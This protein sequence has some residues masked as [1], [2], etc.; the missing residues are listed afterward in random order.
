MAPPTQLSAS[1]STP[2]AASLILLYNPIS[3]HGHLDSWNALFIGFLLEAGWRVASLSPGAE[4]LRARLGLRQLAQHPNLKILAWRTPARSFYQRVRSRVTRL[5]KQL[6]P[7]A[8]LDPAQVAQL[9]Q[10]EAAYLQPQEFAE[11]V[12][13]ATQQLGTRPAFVFNMYMDLYRND[14]LGWRPFRDLHAI[15]WGGIRFVPSSV[16]P[17]EAYYALSSLAGMCFLDEQVQQAYSAA[18]PHKRFEYL[19]DV[20][21]ASLP[22]TASEFVLDLK[23]RAA[24]RKIVFLGGTIGSNKN[25]SQ[26]FALIAQANPAQWFFVQLGEVHE[27]NLTT[28]DLSAYR[29]A[30]A[31]TPEN[32]FIYPQY[33]PDER[34][35]N[36]VIALSDIIFAVYRKFGI[37]SNM[38][39]KAAAFEKPIL[40]AEGY[41]MGARVSA[42]QI[43]LAVP[44]DDSAKMLQALTTLA[45]PLASREVA[46]PKHFAAYRQ[47]FSHDALK[48]KFFH[49]LEQAGARSLGLT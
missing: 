22:A 3:G 8:N 12:A 1:R 44:E 39:G 48:A 49:F 20:T 47:D 38:P 37:S 25:L 17:D 36:E 15:P 2:E 43:G 46:L 18:L 13:D 9:K 6:V 45:Q 21:D 19:P 27:Q 35:F 30:L 42:Y 28:D 34:T 40:V 16:P 11:R 32:V 5:F 33:L 14:S 10:L 7:T 26:W 31:T 4:D 23:K 41:L 24:G 29:Q